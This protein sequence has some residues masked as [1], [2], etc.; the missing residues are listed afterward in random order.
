MIILIE[1]ARTKKQ[2]ELRYRM[3]LANWKKEWR[4]AEE[5]QDSQRL[6]ELHC[7]WPRGLIE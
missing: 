5:Q 2:Q 1:E 6:I 3:E 4:E 7:Q